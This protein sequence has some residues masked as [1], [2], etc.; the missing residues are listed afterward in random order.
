MNRIVQTGTFRRGSTITVP[1]N[2][3]NCAHI[4]DALAKALY[5]KLFDWIVDKIN[6]AMMNESKKERVCISVLNIYGFEI[7]D[8]CIFFVIFTI[9]RKMHLNNFVLIM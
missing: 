5:D 7:F 6:K 9:F 2:A 1:Q 4:S 3:A 8:V